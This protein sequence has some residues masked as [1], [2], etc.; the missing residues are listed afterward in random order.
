ME[1]PNKCH[2]VYSLWS[3]AEN[4][5]RMRYRNEKSV[6]TGSKIELTLPKFY[7]FI[8]GDLAFYADVLGMPNS[9]S[10]WCPWCLVSHKEWQAEP[11]TFVAEERTSKFLK[12][13]YEAIRKD[14][15]NRLKPADKK[16][17]S[18]EMHYK[19]IGPENFVPPLLHME[20]GMVN[21]SWDMFEDWID[22]CVEIIPTHEKEA[23]RQL[24]IA[25]EKLKEA[26]REKEEFTK[27]SSIEIREKNGEIKLL[28]SE[29]QKKATDASRK[30]ELHHQLTLL[31]SLV[32][33]SKAKEKAIKEKYQNC[34]SAT[35]E[36]KKNRKLPRGER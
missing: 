16:G 26:A 7:L 30:I 36:A 12:E 19:G 20:M 25:K 11:N 9:S 2:L 5:F 28:K 27:T 29:I 35:S 14:S 13:T 8:T 33:E 4:G 10:Y 18:T 3:G 34:Q 17:V 24:A 6:V 32:A 23:R 21:Q 22:N 15:K 31:E 1:D